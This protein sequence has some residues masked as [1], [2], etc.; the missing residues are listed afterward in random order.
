MKL[1]E[2]KE[3]QNNFK[4]IK[5][6]WRKLWKLKKIKEIKE[7]QQEFKENQGNLKNIKGIW[8]TVKK[9]PE[10]YRKL[11]KIKWN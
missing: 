11:K 3:N 6:N 4:I 10:K 5:G 7:N 9:I 1:R 8:R 2:I